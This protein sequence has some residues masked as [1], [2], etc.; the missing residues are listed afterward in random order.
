MDDVLE[1]EYD[2]QSEP[3]Y[4]TDAV[5]RL[6]VAI[7]SLQV[8]YSSIQTNGL[9]QASIE[10]LSLIDDELY[11]ALPKKGYTQGPSRQGLFDTLKEV[12]SRLAAL[13]KEFF[14]QLF[15][16][17]QRICTYILERITHVKRE[18]AEKAMAYGNEQ[19]IKSQKAY[20]A[21]LE[22]R[23]KDLESAHIPEDLKRQKKDALDAIVKGTAPA[24]A[25]ALSEADQAYTVLVRAI[26]KRPAQVESLFGYVNELPALARI[27]VRLV[28]NLEIVFD[29]LR[30]VTGPEDLND[31]AIVLRTLD[32]GLESLTR[33]I[34]QVISK[35]TD[36]NLRV[37]GEHALPHIA[38]H[39]HSNAD[40]LR[41]Y[42]DA[43]MQA[44]E[45]PSG[46]S[47]AE[48]YPDSLS[49]ITAARM[50]VSDALKSVD[51][52]FTACT[53]DFTTLLARSRELTEY[54]RKYNGVIIS[55][56]ENEQQIRKD[57]ITTNRNIQRS[58]LF[59]LRLR[60]IP[61]IVRGN[62]QRHMSKTIRRINLTGREIGNV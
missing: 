57:L 52:V 31:A 58:V 17:I 23:I 61:D 34:C 11:D 46:K 37:Y 48:E 53:E 15:E 49:E 39:E 25:A 26:Y 22:K 24:V 2:D 8:F 42:R 51:T 1:L 28:E 36:R 62:L 20:I 9:S 16:L 35:A 12:S 19:V 14:V 10:S 4:R 13:G 44:A 54:V 59:L 60:S 29:K 27:S 5:E 40:Y 18:S 7:E 47:F 21:A 32:Q 33:R 50:V 45:T 56:K 41:E 3:L 55:S 30:N 38:Y 43:L 6:D